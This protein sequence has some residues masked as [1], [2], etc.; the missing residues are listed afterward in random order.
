MQSI[1]VVTNAFRL[2][3]RLGRDKNG[4]KIVHCSSRVTNA[5]R[6]LVRLGRINILTSI[7]SA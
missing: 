4:N 2:L 7:T 1:R 3:V 6:L 5:F